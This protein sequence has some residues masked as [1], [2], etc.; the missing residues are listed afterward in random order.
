VPL[1][2]GNLAG[3]QI[4]S[5]QFDMLFDPQIVE[6]AGVDSAG[7]FSEGMGTAW[8]VAAPGL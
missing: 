4:T 5:Y 1:T 6:V 7:T 2:V 8:N 3:Q